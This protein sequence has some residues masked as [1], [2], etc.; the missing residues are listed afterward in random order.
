[1]DAH[2]GRQHFQI[3]FLEWNDRIPIQISLIFVAKDPIENNWALV[4]IMAW[5]RLGDK[6]LSEPI[7]T[8]YTDAY[9]RHYREMI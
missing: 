1:M 8:K 4:W 6:P 7:M 9:M 5:R 3:N 2:S